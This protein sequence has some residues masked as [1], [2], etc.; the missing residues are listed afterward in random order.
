VAA[1]LAARTV[2]TFLP[3]YKSERQWS[4]RKVDL[5]LPLF[6]GYIFVRIRLEERVRVLEA[7]GVIYL[8]GAGGRPEAIEDAEIE[9]LRAAVDARPHVYG[10][11]N[12]VKPGDR[13]KVIS[14]PMQG[15]Q[16]FLVRDKGKCRVVVQV[17]LI[18]R[19]MSM[20][21]GMDQIAAAE[22]SSLVLKSTH[23][24]ALSGADARSAPL[25]RGDVASVAA[26]RQQR[27]LGDPLCTNGAGG[28][29]PQMYAG[30]SV[31][32][33]KRSISGEESSALP[34]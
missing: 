9:R 25:E 34:R 13:V 33:P 21:I 26:E 3:Q 10:G 6:A 31:A 32:T 15:T 30:S 18:R 19:S 23:A 14:G 28:I 17:E 29:C 11:E 16:G 1:H 5:M 7:P 4:D 2:E 27:A 8:V 24:F 20:E 12:G 22:K